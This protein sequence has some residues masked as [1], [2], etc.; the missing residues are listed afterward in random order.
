MNDATQLTVPG[1][2]N[3]AEIAEKV[4][5]NNDLTALTAQERLTYLTELCRMLGL[6]PL[7]RPFI[8]IQTEQGLQVYPT[9]EC[10]AQLRSR[11]NATLEIKSREIAGQPGTGQLYIVTVKATLPDGR[12]DEA[13]AAVALE[14][15]TGQWKSTQSGKRYFE[16]TG[17]YKPLSPEQRANQVMRCECVPLDSEI[18]TRAGWKCHN[19]VSPGDEVLAYD[20]TSDTCRWTPLLAVSVYESASLIRLH[21]L[22]FDVRCTP[23]HSWAIEKKGYVPCSDGRRCLRGPYANRGLDRGLI[24]AHALKTS[25]RIILAAPE[26]GTGESVLTPAEAA[27]MGWAITDGTIQ[28]RAS[29]RRI[30]ICQSK[31]ENFAAIR[32]AVTAMVGRPVNECVTVTGSHTFPTGRTYATKPQ[33]WWYLPAD[34]SRSLLEKAG[35]E[36][37]G[38]ECMPNLAARLSSPARRAMLDAMLRADAD[39]RRI[40]TK[41]KRWV[42]DTLQM[43]CILEG[44]ALGREHDR[45]SVIAQ[46]LKKTRHIAVNFLKKE[47]AG[48]AAVWCPT[49]E[50]GTWVMRQNRTVTITGN[51]KAKRRATFSIA[52]L[53][54][55]DSPDTSEDEYIP[56][57]PVIDQT[58]AIESTPAGTPPAPAAP[59]QQPPPNP[60]LES[61]LNKLGGATREQR[62][63]MF[64]DLEAQLHEMLGDEGMTFY[65]EQLRA[66]GA[67]EPGELKTLA[68]AKRV[69]AALWQKMAAGVSAEEPVA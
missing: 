39:K 57:G 63:G 43:L 4:L 20:C 64:A 52:G 45:P 58:P 35:F 8:L 5:L 65:R 14:T 61:Q 68:I 54:M 49:T 62:I 50:Y 1:D 25:H 38:H 46:T 56:R 18:L 22:N 59:V 69:Y 26:T 12:S 21:S 10:A 11:M 44:I 47:D 34:A 32:E 27:V 66:E 30:A 17:Q 13:L 33:R 31:E 36:D 16:G 40:F 9:K 2:R 41:G 7:T 6:N 42:M 37:G 55:S 60:A 15:E 28:R 24:K 67:T 51:T 48:T 3:L 23:D 29:H 53:G 19:Q